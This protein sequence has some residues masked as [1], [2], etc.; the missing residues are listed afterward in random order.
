[1]VRA[2]I[3]NLRQKI[4]PDPRNPTYIHTIFGVGYMVRS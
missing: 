3:R 2:L 4:E 1:M